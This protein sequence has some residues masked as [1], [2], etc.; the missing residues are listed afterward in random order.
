M[1]MGGFWLVVKGVH[2]HDTAVEAVMGDAPSP[3]GILDETYGVKVRRV[4]RLKRPSS[5]LVS[6]SR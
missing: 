5:T 2:T 3:V 1:V 6:G 4:Q